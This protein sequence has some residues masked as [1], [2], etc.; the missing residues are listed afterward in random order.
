MIAFFRGLLAPLRAAGI[1]LS[2]PG[3]ILLALLPAFAALL[4]S[5]LG[6]WLA[7]AY[8]DDLFLYLWPEPSSEG[9]WGVALHSVWQLISWLIQISSAFL[10]LFITPWLVM[11]LGLPLCEPLAARVDEILGGKT[12][13]GSFITEILGALSTTLGVVILGLGG[14]LLFSLLGLIPGVALIIAP[15]LLFIWTP[16]FLTFDLYD[17][18]LSRRQLSFGQKMKVLM[19]QPLEGIGLGLVGT[20]LLATPLLNLFGLPVAVVGAVLLIRDREKAGSLPLAK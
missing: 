7:L 9:F 6:V 5:I 14:S 13:E 4:L 10:A 18:S 15:F 16:L 8:G 12:R 2:H 1:F 20:A 3:L 17:S 19:T 11:L